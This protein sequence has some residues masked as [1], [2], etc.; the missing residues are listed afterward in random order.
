MA[1]RREA[2]DAITVIRVKMT[3]AF[4]ASAKASTGHQKTAECGSL[5][6]GSVLLGMW[7]RCKLGYRQC[8]AHH[9]DHE[10][11]QTEAKE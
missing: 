4:S 8:S 1:M 10:G 9:G 11:L 7:R 2:A 3:V 6:K 5:V